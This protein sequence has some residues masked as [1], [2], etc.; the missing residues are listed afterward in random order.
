MGSKNG[1][2]TVIA[3]QAIKIKRPGVHACYSL[4]WAGFQ[5]HV[6]VCKFFGMHFSGRFNVSYVSQGCQ[7]LILIGCR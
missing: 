7:H 4:Q 2:K 5:N 3:K 1:V 6:K